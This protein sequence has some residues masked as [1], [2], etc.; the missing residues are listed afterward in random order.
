M[1]SVID[2][3]HC[4]N[5]SDRTGGL[6]ALWARISGDRYY[7]FDRG[8]TDYTQVSAEWIH[9]NT[10]IGAFGTAYPD[11]MFVPEGN[12]PPF[13][14]L[15]HSDLGRQSVLNGGVREADMSPSICL[16]TV[17]SDTSTAPQKK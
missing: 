13:L 12:T 3:I 15:I 11:F 8:G 6:V 10:Q 17:T 16:K 7:G 5:R 2:I 9:E 14:H 1:S 4:L